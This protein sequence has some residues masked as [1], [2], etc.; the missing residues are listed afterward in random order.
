MFVQ[1][2]CVQY[3]ISLSKVLTFVVCDIPNSVC[4]CECV[5]IVVSSVQ[6]FRPRTPPEA[7]DLVSKLL[8]YTPAAR[9]HPM[10]ACAHPFFNELRLPDA[11]M[12]S[13]PAFPP[14]FNFTQQGQRNILVSIFVSLRSRIM[15][16]LSLL[17]QPT[18]VH[19]YNFFT[20]DMIPFTNICAVSYEQHTDVE[21]VPPCYRFGGRFLFV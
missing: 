15:D 5:A 2:E 11:K 7:I 19:A 17:Y 21:S 14:L 20:N 9:L 4:L 6:V 16:Y 3:H 13:G 10:E 8:E 12:P 18:V 1:F